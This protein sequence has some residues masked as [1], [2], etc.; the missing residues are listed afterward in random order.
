MNTRTVAFCCF[1]W[2]G[3]ILSASPANALLA[4]P[5]LLPE[6]NANVS[7]HWENSEAIMCDGM[8][9]ASYV[10]RMN[11][12]GVSMM[13]PADQVYPTGRKTMQLVGVCDDGTHV[14]ELYSCP[15]DPTLAD[16]ELA[17]LA[18]PDRLNGKANAQRAEYRS[19]LRRDEPEGN[20]PVP[21]SALASEDWRRHLRRSLF[22]LRG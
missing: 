2:A 4:S 21:S 20:P 19:P 11:L 17:Q 10:Q 14:Y 16:P 9:P 3:A 1:V 13:F 12:G 6:G 18:S 22:T 8:I 15:C 7:A 5:I